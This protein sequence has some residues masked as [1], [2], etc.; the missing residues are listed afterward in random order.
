MIQSIGNG[1]RKCVERC[2]DFQASDRQ[3]HMRIHYR[4]EVPLLN[5]FPIDGVEDAKN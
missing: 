2:E 1:K 3:S 4:H 5:A